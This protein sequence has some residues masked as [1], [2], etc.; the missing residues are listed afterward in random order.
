MI[1]LC[2]TQSRRRLETPTP[3]TTKEVGKDK[4]TMIA[5]FSTPDYNNSFHPYEQSSDYEYP[6]LVSLDSDSDET[7]RSLSILT[8]NAV[9]H[10]VLS[11]F[12]PRTCFPISS[13]SGLTYNLLQGTT[14]T[15]NIQDY[16]IF[17]FAQPKSVQRIHDLF[18]ECTRNY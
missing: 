11:F 16:L 18:F 1:T 7:Y 12:Q 6:D 2:H 9:Y 10:S 15:S 3:L 17:A 13:P 4:R 8:K 14:S 5:K